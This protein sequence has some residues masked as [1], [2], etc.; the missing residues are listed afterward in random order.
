MH[1]GRPRLPPRRAAVGPT[2]DSPSNSDQVVNWTESEHLLPHALAVAGQGQKLEVESERWLWLLA[3]SATYLWSRG[4]HQQGLTLEEQTLT[5]Y[6]RVLGENHPDPLTSL[7]NLAATLRDLGDFQG[8]ASFREQTLA[9]QWVLRE[10][11]PNTRTFKEQH[12][13]SPSGTWGTV[14]IVR[15]SLALLQVLQHGQT[16]RR[17][18]N[19]TVTGEPASPCGP[20]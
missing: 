11:H 8:P 16:N 12:R 3:Q 14:A 17:A 18:A 15:R 13:P 10:D 1:T 5:T 6:R 19:A 2:L 4:R 9:A 7:D 20:G